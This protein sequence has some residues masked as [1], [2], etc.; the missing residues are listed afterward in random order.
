M[1]QR[2]SF[3]ILWKGLMRRAARHARGLP[4]RTTPCSLSKS[5]QHTTEFA[6]LIG[7]VTLAALTMQFVARRGLQT[8]VKM[9]SDFILDEPPPPE[10]E[11]DPEEVLLEVESGNRTTEQGT[12]AFQR[13]TKVEETI[14]GRSASK[15]T[16]LQV[17][18]E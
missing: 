17:F 4:R 12:A 10:P 7:L 1:S 8:G 6:I 9:V 3:I 2:E 11:G 14:E 16:R 5:G 13:A 18:K 15:E